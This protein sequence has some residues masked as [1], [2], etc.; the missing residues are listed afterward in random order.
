MAKPNTLQI[1]PELAGEIETGRLYAYDC[2]TV[3]DLPSP[4]WGTFAVVREADGGEHYFYVGCGS[5]WKRVELK[6]D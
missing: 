3:S 1:H 5:V 2:D 6:E 4:A